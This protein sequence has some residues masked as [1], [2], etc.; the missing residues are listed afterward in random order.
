M[1]RIAPVTDCPC[2]AHVPTSL[3]GTLGHRVCEGIPVCYGPVV[4]LAGSFPNLKGASS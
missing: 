3:N 1:L 4:V 2:S